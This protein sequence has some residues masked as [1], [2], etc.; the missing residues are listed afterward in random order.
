MDQ[1]EATIKS[2]VK[3]ADIKINGKRPWDIQVYDPRFFSRALTE[4]SVGFG[5]S[6]M[7]GDWDSGQLDET[8]ARIVKA[9]LGNKI[10]KS[11]NLIA[12]ILKSKLINVASKSRSF[13]VGQ[14]HYDLG[15]ELYEAMLDPD[16]NYSC[17]YW[18]DATTLHEAQIAKL[19][20]ICRKLYLKKGL[21]V[22]DIGC[23]WGSF[24]KYAA[25][26]YGVDVLGVTVSKEQA[27]LAQKRCKG[28][29]VKIKVIDYRDIKERNF[30][31]IVSIGMFEHVNYKN[32]ATFMKIAKESLKKDGLFLLHT[33]GA[34]ESLF[35]N[36]P[37]IDK[38]IFPNGLVPSLAQIAKSAERKFI[39]EDVHNFGIY[40]YPTLMSW[41]KNFHK[42]WKVLSKKYPEKYNKRFYRMWEY[43]LLSCAGNFKARGLQLY[44]VV[45]S[46]GNAYKPYQS[47]R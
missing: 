31:R 19:D 4:G 18:K 37:W 36:E 10:K 7:D 27:Q 44:Q 22:L 20:L 15:N 29:P 8:I 9:E 17:G 28:L 5:E 46:Q 32:H 33:I 41:Y 1:A 24:A 25:E 14:H 42:S 43:Y 16:L 11:L 39:I 30:D 40:Y 23:G 34:N 26:K 2:L 38:Y 6:Y 12:F 47:V 35:S 45:L 3:L 21:K 13:K